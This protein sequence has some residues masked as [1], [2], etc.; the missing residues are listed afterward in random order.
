MN[1]TFSSGGVKMFSVI[2]KDY[3]GNKYEQ[4]C[5][6][7]PGYKKFNISRKKGEKANADNKRSKKQHDKKFS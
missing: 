4:F 6:I 2:L 1:I 5:F 3:R 7:E